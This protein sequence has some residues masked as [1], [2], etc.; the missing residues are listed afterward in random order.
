LIL[1]PGHRLDSDLAVRARCLGEV[2]GD[3]AGCGFGGDL[4]RHGPLAGLLDI[5]CRG[6]QDQCPGVSEGV[7]LRHRSRLKS[8]RPSAA[9]IRSFSAVASR[10]ASGGLPQETMPLQWLGGRDT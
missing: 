2:D 9:A 7:V 10:S 4:S 8:M 3:E 5:G 6:L 1:A